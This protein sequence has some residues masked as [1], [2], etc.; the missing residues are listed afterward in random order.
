[1]TAVAVAPPRGRQERTEW[2]APAPLWSDVGAAASG[3]LQ[4][5][6]AE[7]T[8]DSF[9]ADFLGMLAGT[10]GRSPDELAT[11]VPQTTVDGTATGTFR[12]FQPL[13]RRYYLVTATLACQRP[14]IPDRL[15]HPNRGERASFV[16]RQL[17]THGGELGFVPGSTGGSWRPATAD[18]LVDG[19]QE[20]PMHPAAVT[21]FAAPGTTAAALGMAADRGHPRT[22]LFGYI[23]V[24]SRDAMVPPMADPAQALLDLPA[25]S[26][27]ENPA[28]DELLIRVVQPWQRLRDAAPASP[29]YPSLFL[30]LDLSDWLQRHLL[31][32]YQA[33]ISGT[34]PTAGPANNLYQR[35][36]LV[37]VQTTTPNGP[38]ATIGLDRAIKDL[39]T[40]VPLVTGTEMDG[41]ATTYDLLAATLPSNWLDGPAT[42]ASLANLARAALS[43][44][45]PVVPSELQGLIK[46]DPVAVAGTPGGAGPTYVIRTVFSHEPCRPVLSVPTRPFE[47]AR[48][49]DPDAPARPIL[50]QL[51]DVSNLRKFKRG[52]AIEMSPNLRRL[53]DR[54]TPDILKGGGLGPDPGVQLGMVCAFSLQIIFLVAFIV[55]FI[56]LILLNIVFWWLPF[57]KVCFPVPV[58]PSTPR[59][60]TP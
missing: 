8:S 52:V 45:V 25:S 16:I 10:G 33:I 35:I 2:L 42:A 57:L 44:A 23:P 28:L 27:H 47:M 39:D 29:G 31:P 30:I 26:P 14:G 58:P 56:F 46:N 53:M 5:W 32:V 4:P 40:F 3:L 12:L 11:T 48:A 43:G 51:P 22:V 37:S 7:L 1:V 19:E 21:P 13:N 24:A 41:P 6:I 9:M 18:A 15:V 50:L 17:D 54:V 36:K 60:P 34:P 59:G 20:H 55:M 38:A 49:L